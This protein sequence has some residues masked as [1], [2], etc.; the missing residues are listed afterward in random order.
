M[1]NG[2]IVKL[3][4][5]RLY[6]DGT[7]YSDTKQT[8]SCFK[9]YPSYSRFAFVDTKDTSYQWKWVEATVGG[10]KLLICKTV[11]FDFKMRV[12]DD[13]RQTVTLDGTR[14]AFRILTIEEFRSLGNEILNQIDF[15]MDSPEEGTYNTLYVAT[16]TILSPNGKRIFAG[17][18]RLGNL[19]EIN[20]TVDEIEAPNSLYSNIGYLPIL[21]EIKS[22]P[23]IS[24]ADGYLGNK[25]EPFS[26]PYSVT[27]D[28][29][30]DEVIITEKING[31]IRRTL[32]NPPHGVIIYFDVYKEIFDYLNMD[33]VNTLEIVA[34]NNEA[35]AYRRYT[36][37]RGNSAPKIKYDGKIDLGELTSKPTITYSVQDNE[38]DIVTVTEKLNGDVIR[39]FNA[40]LNR[41]YSITFTDDFWITCNSSLNKV[42]IIATDALGTSSSK[43]ITFSRQV[44]K[45]QF[46]T[47]RPIQTSTAAT[48]IMVN[49]QWEIT[50]ATGKVEVC[51]NGFDDNPTWEEMTT[52][53]ISSEPYTFINSTKTADKWGIKIRI[54]IIKNEGATNE[55][56]IYGFGGSYE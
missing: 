30:N 24:G 5:L 25:T 45:I 10:R 18:D 23:N 20:K 56:A 39:T 43:T 16:T 47:K 2:D 29:P 26:V 22:V 44:N 27:T 28:D 36:F 35:T 42:E 8:P 19:E 41:N 46:V 38:G 49:P 6:S 13:I 9:A 54:T 52:E 4:T 51:N 11:P 12:L 33:Q 37:G 40:T 34:T 53:A 17:R 55:V 3:G 1:A 15:N 21:E 7:T 31:N 32:K 50:N 14:Y 48:K